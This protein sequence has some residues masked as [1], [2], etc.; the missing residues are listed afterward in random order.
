MQVS[1]KTIRNMDT[2]TIDTTMQLAVRFPYRWLGVLASDQVRRLGRVP[3]GSCIIINTDEIKKPGRHWVGV[4]KPLLPLK[5]DTVIFFDSYALPVH[6]LVPAIG[7]WLAQQGHNIIRSPFA[8]QQFMSAAC[9]PLTMFVL[10]KLPAYQNNLPQLI[11]SEFSK[12]DLR[13]NES[14]AYKYLVSRRIN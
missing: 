11:R 13:S 2:H 12:T 8:I 6:H 9:G 1:S 7:R 3:P 4:L 5:S 10:L 14:K